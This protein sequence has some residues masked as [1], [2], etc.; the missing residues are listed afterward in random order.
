MV[1]PTL[2]IDYFRKTN[3]HNTRLVALSREFERLCISSI[4]EFEI[5]SGATF[6]QIDFWNEFLKK[7]QVFSFDS[8]AAQIAVTV[9]QDLKRIR[10]SIDKADLFIAATAISNNL[11]LDTLN[12]KH[13]DKISQLS[14]IDTNIN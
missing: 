13:F 1:Y 6:P 9:L 12:R 11:S 8:K 3:K 5:Y 10:V 14:L 2:F 7:F 4:T